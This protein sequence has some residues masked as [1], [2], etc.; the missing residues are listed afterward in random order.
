MSKFISHRNEKIREQ[1]ALGKKVV[2][3]AHQ[4]EAMRS[5]ALSRPETSF[6]AT[7]LVFNEDSVQRML[8]TVTPSLETSLLP[9]QENV[10]VA[11]TTEADCP[12]MVQ[13]YTV[14]ILDVS[15]QNKAMAYILDQVIYRVPDRED[16][17]NERFYTVNPENDGVL[18]DLLRFGEEKDNEAP[19]SEVFNADGNVKE[20][21]I[22]YNDVD[23]CARGTAGQLK[24][25]TLTMPACNLP[26]VD[27]KAIWSKV[28][29]GASDQLC[30]LACVASPKEVAQGNVRLSA[31]CASSTPLLNVGNFVVYM[32]KI[33]DDLGNE[34]KDGF[35]MVASEFVAE[36]LTAIDPKRYFVMPDAPAGISL[37]TRPWTCKVM[38]QCVMRAYLKEFV[39]YR[40]S[41]DH[42]K[43]VTIY[44]DEVDDK[45]QAKFTKTV[46]SKGKEGAYAGKWV[47]IVDS[48]KSDEEAADY[49]TDL[50]GL[51]APFD[52]TRM[53]GLNALDMSHTEHHPESGANAS[54]QSI[55]SAMVIDPVATKVWYE[56]KMR[57][58]IESIR[59]RLLADEG[60]A[61]T[62]AEISSGNVDIPQLIGRIAPKFVLENY[63]PIF[64][65]NIDN[66]C[67]GLVTAFNRL[68]VTV[69]GAYMKLTTDPAADFGARILTYSKDG[70]CEVI[71]PVANAAKWNRM[72]LVKYP[73]MHFR[74][75]AKA[76]P[77]SL[78][79]YARR[80]NA[81]EKLTAYQKKLI[82]EQ[83]GK[84]TGGN[85]AIPALE[86]LKNMLAGMDFDGDACVGYGEE[87]DGEIGFVDILWNVTPLAVVID[88][89]VKRKADDKAF[90]AAL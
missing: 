85:I 5:L 37:Q 64:R 31:F 72:I 77:V 1:R 48:R 33:K 28:T 25:S 12:Q 75:F 15:I 34:F 13:R 59:E 54:S 78:A 82:I 52:L 40:I 24:L 51:K 80:V 79:E 20:D 46:F 18:I 8:I 30:Q 86:E 60:S 57:A 47:R 89:D 26:G 11:A 70:E 53:S 69:P 27:R 4:V 58:M 14:G 7:S 38:A 44:R 66:A 45:I 76:V 90:E 17:V 22:V 3:S 87:S 21:V 50:N 23:S 43:M 6:K 67:K 63:A 9:M 19:L 49:A 73:K 41:V 88:T 74:E 56:R 83:A 68:N 35:A 71:S 32:G 16:G 81:S 10:L 2:L 84:M 42:T 36:C 61:P 62:Y 55:Q 29:Y 65:S 39:N